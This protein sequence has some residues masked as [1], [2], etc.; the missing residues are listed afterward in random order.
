M[1][2]ERWDLQPCAEDG[3]RDLEHLE[4][5][6]VRTVALDTC[7]WR[8]AHPHQQIARGATGVV[9]GEPMPWDA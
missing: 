6:E 7:I 3:V 4:A 9:A 8:T 5:P 2:I 1:A